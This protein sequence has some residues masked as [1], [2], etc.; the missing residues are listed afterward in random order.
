M[1]VSG[2]VGV[3]I[4]VQIWHVGGIAGDIDDRLKDIVDKALGAQACLR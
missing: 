3:G 2:D 4:K 1:R